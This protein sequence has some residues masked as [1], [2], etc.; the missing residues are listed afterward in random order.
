[1]SGTGLE[2]HDAASTGDYD[3]LEE[4]IKTGKYDLNLKDVDSGNR[5]A[6]H[7]ACQKGYV[8]C[9]RLLLENGAKGTARTTTG[10]T[11]AHCA[12]ESNR[13]PA[14]RALHAAHV[15]VDLKDKYGDTPRRLATIYGHVDC[16]R[17]LLQAESEL[18]ERRR[19]NGIT[20][21]EEEEYSDDDKDAL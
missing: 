14:L 7:W 9:I 20:E 21:E 2:I 16:V 11:P 3:S 5:T 15:P 19:K 1:M 8:E 13:V 4:L 6:L 18:A 12:A 17:Y 10:W